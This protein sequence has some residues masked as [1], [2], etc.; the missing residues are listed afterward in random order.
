MSHTVKFKYLNHRG[1]VAERHVEI[2]SIDFVNNPGYNYQPGWFISGHD[3]DKNA[4]RSFALS[5]IVISDDE[6]PP[7]KLFHLAL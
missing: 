5:R 7:P 1:E 6:N 2:A 3:L 4:Y